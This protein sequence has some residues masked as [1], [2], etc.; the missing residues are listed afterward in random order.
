MSNDLGKVGG[1]PTPRKRHKVAFISITEF[2]IPLGLD[3]VTHNH[4]TNLV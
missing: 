4:R 3:R 1:R 2:L